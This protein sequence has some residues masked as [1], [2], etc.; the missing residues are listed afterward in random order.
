MAEKRYA[1]KVILG[2]GTC[3][4]WNGDTLYA[5]VPDRRH[6]GDLASGLNGLVEEDGWLIGYKR[7]DPEHEL[8]RIRMDKC[9]VIVWGGRP[10]S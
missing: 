8:M 10:W 5:I 9:A 7:F 6:T 2:D 3:I 1:S 4:E